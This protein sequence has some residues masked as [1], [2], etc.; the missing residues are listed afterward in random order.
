[1]IILPSLLLGAPLTLAADRVTPVRSHHFSIS[2]MVTGEPDSTD[3]H[4][5]DQNYA[6]IFSQS[7]GIARAWALP[8][9]GSDSE[10]LMVQR[11][12]RDLEGT[13]NQSNGAPLLENY[14]KTTCTDAVVVC[15]SS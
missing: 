15:A 3:Y 2:E 12:A 13:E 1:M 11:T 7:P 14:F 9:Q 4:A 6:A 5:I 10:T 8:T